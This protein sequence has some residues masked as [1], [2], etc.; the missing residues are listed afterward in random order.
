MPRALAALT[1]LVLCLAFALPAPARTEYPEGW[2]WHGAAI[3]SGSLTAQ[4][5]MAL[6]GIIDLNFVAIQI[7]PRLRASREHIAPEEALEKE[8]AWATEM[9]DACRQAHLRALLVWYNIPI[10]PNL[11][12]DQQKPQFWDDPAQVAEMVRLGG[13]LAQRFKNRG[14]E[15]AGYQIQSEPVVYVAGRPR[16][17]EVW[18]DALDRIIRAIRA[19]DP[20]R[21]IAASLTMGGSPDYAGC[22]PLPYPRII[23]NAHMYWP[24]AY[25][26]QGMF[27]YKARPSYP[28]WTGLTYLDR[29]AL[30]RTLTPLALFSSTY[31]VPVWIG[32]FS[33]VRW[34][35][36]AEQYLRDTVSLFNDFGF[37]WSYFSLGA[38]H[39]W[40]PDYNTQYSEVSDRA[41]WTSQYVGQN[42]PRWSTLRELFTKRHPGSPAAPLGK[43]P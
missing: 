7:M 16:L 17:P 33:A 23:Y 32:E 25:T 41:T 21:W 6:P 9:L 14:S 15:L 20:D 13:V 40:N 22:K 24:H 19:Q 26:Y 27:E 36:G 38:F 11:G 34:A 39:C 1:A 35:E 4:D 8:F 31:G 30:A 5:V 28:G 18:P 3:L 42:S 10:D 43:N 37:S 2:P 29:K 12:F